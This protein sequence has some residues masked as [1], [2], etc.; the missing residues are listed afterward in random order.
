MT[1]DGPFLFTTT[2]FFCTFADAFN[3]CPERNLLR[4]TLIWLVAF[5]PKKFLHENIE[6]LLVNHRFVSD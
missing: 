6:S 3:H 4:H 2:L 5:L 1:D